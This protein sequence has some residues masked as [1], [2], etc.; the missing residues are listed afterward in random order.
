MKTP[1]LILPFL[2]LGCTSEA[3][4]NNMKPDTP[5]RD[6]V[7]KNGILLSIEGID[8]SKYEL[9][10]EDFDIEKVTKHHLLCLATDECDEALVTQLLEKGVDVNFRCEEGDHVITNLAFC[11]EN[12]VELTKLLLNKG[13]NINGA[14]Q[15]NDS[16]LSYA[17]SSDNL[18]LVTF[19]LDRGA[20]RMQRDTNRNMG[21]LPVH[22]VKS[23]EMLSL[24]ISKG[25]DINQRCDNGRNL[26]HFAAKDDLPQVAQYLIEKR[27]VDINQKDKNG[28]TPLDYAIK[29]HHPEIAALLKKKK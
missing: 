26:L 6:V 27:L 9:N 7:V 5:K 14:D 28:E 4:K 13:A 25:F 1:L 23:V 12:G 15:E 22:G 24:L 2:L 8:V 17:I 19:L 21:C 18:N 29:Y 16:F 10:V 20:D 3:Q 11:M